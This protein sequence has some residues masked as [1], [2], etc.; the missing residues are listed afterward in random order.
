MFLSGHGPGWKALG[1][2]STLRSPRGLSG[3][4]ARARYS[5]LALT[6]LTSKSTALLPAVQFASCSATYLKSMFAKVSQPLSVASR[7]AWTTRALFA[8]NP[9]PTQ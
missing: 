3:K 6:G 4:K 1:S 9:L 5:P 2:I 8:P 7:S